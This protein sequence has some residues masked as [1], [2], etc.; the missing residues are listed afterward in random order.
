[1]KKGTLSKERIARLDV[2]GFDFDPFTTQWEEKYLSLVAF[3]NKHDHCNV[4]KRFNADADKHCLAVE[5]G[6]GRMLRCIKANQSQV[7]AQCLTALKDTGL[8]D[9]VE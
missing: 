3:K 8:W 2:I 5:P 4:P 9:L 6:E 1:M 7:S